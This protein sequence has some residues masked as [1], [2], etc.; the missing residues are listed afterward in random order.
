LINKHVY[1]DAARSK[2]VLAKLLDFFS[3]VEVGFA[4]CLI[5]TTSSIQDYEDAVLEEAAR[6]TGIE[7]IITRNGEDFAGGSVPVMTAGAYLQ[8]L[9]VSDT[10]RP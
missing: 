7:C 9:L 6:R 10:P 8:K 2:A 1:H 5:A 4:D 3:V